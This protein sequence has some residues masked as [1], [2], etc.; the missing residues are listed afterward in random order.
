[1]G[2][3]KCQP[4]RYGRDIVLRE[5]IADLGNKSAATQV[6]CDSAEIQTGMALYF[7]FSPFRSYNTF[8]IFMTTK[9]LTQFPIVLK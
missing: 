5:M 7:S 6:R 3:M 1:V 8:V 9:I 2:S 4:Q